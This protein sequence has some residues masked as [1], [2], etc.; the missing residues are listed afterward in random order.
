[1]I[2]LSKLS[3]EEK[4]AIREEILAEER[5]DKDQQ[6]K[7]KETYEQIKDLQ[8]RATFKELQKVSD[9]L[10]VNKE[11][12]FDDFKTILRMKKELYHLSDEKMAVQ[13]S[14][15]FTTHDGSMSIIIGHNIIDR[16]NETVSVGIGKINEWLTKLAKDDESAKLVGFIR[17]LMKPNKEGALK[18]NRVLDLSKKAA[19]IGDKELIIAV[20]LIRD[21]YRP[22]RT[23]TFIKAKYKDDDG[24]DQF[25]ALSMSA[26]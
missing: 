14:H 25:L 20:D 1:M 17:D 11:K 2:D 6:K 4:A 10:T 5:A 12:V 15:T 3:P 22:E 21:A 13:Q 24:R 8:V 19:E 23:S 7:E 18:A 9:L 26:V 16:W